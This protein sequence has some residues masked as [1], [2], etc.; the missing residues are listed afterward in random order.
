MSIAAADASVSLFGLYTTPSGATVGL[1]REGLL[2]SQQLMDAE[3][4]DYKKILYI[5][6]VLVVIWALFITLLVTAY[7][8]CLSGVGWIP[9]LLNSLAIG[10]FLNFASQFIVFWWLFFR[11]MSVVRYHQ[12]DWPAWLVYECGTTFVGLSMSIL[13]YLLTTSQFRKRG[14]PL[15]GGLGAS[16]RL[17]LRWCCGPV[18]WFEAPIK[19]VDKIPAD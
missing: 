19:I 2:T 16:Y 9:F 3:L 5:S 13:L 14:N 18:E 8:G 7:F 10:S 1:L 15:Y 12:I 17:F 4:W 6:R 11:S